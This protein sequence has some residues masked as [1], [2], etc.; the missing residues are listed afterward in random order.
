[1]R[2]SRRSDSRFANWLGHPARIVL[3]LLVSTAG[4]CTLITDVDR[5]RI[6][7]PPQLPFPEVDACPKLRGRAT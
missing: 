3:L 6:P 1:M 4:A 2:A 7:D 5:E